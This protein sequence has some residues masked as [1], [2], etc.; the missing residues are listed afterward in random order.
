VLNNYSKLAKEVVIISASGEKDAVWETELAKKI[1]FKT[2]LITCSP[3]SSAAKIADQV[4][5]Y[6]KLP[7]PYT[8]NTSTY[9]GMILGQLVKKQKISKKSS[10]KLKYL[11]NLDN[12]KPTLLSYL[13][14]FKNLARC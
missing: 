7:E 12:T 13:T 9:L 14:D 10:K 2:F 6:S 4:F 5:S 1:G 3:D 11:K 8:Y